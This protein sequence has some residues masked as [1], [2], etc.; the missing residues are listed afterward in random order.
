MN[1]RQ[2]K[3][4]C[5]K[6]AEIMGFRNCYEEWTDSTYTKFELWVED[7]VPPDGGQGSR[8]CWEFLSSKYLTMDSGWNQYLWFGNEYFRG[9]P[10]TPRNVFAWA[11]QQEWSK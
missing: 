7:L 10:P 2:H 11:R 9:L 1:N 3:K 4:L 5:K 6:A 8:P